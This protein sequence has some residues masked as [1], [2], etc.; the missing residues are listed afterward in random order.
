MV[1][2]VYTTF[3]GENF[4]DIE[5]AKRYEQ[6]K[7]EHSPVRNLGN[8][9][10]KLKKGETPSI[11]E[12]EYIY[13]PKYGYVFC[14]KLTTGLGLLYNISIHPNTMFLV[15]KYNTNDDSLVVKISWFENKEFG[16][17]C[18]L[19]KEGI[20]FVQPIKSGEDTSGIVKQLQKYLSEEAYEVLKKAYKGEI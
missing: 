6:D 19:K 4:D 2:A 17:C 8:V 12:N 16:V 14:S 13:R 20:Q 7:I 11:R 10:Y 18:E 15:D 3:D 5:K 9:L 1:K